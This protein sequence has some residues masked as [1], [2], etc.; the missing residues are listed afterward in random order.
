MR[1]GN[2]CGH[3]T[4][5]ASPHQETSGLK[6]HLLVSVVARALAGPRA[7]VGTGARSDN[8][9]PAPVRLGTGSSPGS[10]ARLLGRGSEEGGR[11]AP[12]HAVGDDAREM[13][14]ERDDIPQRRG[15]S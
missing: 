12:W 9:T 13:S 14:Q 3:G 5:R 4:P 1:C 8:T 10:C 2:R 11:V 6:E 7:A 15:E